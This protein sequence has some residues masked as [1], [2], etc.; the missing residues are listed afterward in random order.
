MKEMVL[1]QHQ[2]GDRWQMFDAGIASQSFCLAAYEQGLGS[3]ILGIFDD[4]KV[5]SI[6]RDS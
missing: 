3:V 2:K 4:A 5:A 6:I 1:S